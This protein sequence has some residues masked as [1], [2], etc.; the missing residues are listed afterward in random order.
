MLP[1]LNSKFLEHSLLNKLKAFTFT[2]TNKRKNKILKAKDTN[3][4]IHL[5]YKKGTKQTKINQSETNI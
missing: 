3:S 1:Y 5:P 4:A 2:F